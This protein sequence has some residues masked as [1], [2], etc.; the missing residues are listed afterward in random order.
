MTRLVVKGIGVAGAFGTGVE[1]F[2]SALAEGRATVGSVEVATGEGVVTVPAYR[3]DTAALEEFVPKRALR[4]VDNYSK[5]ALLGSYLALKDAG[6]LGADLGRLGLV[7]ASGYGA[8][9]TTYAFLDSLISG[10]DT[11]ASPTHFANSVHNA[12]AANV[13]ITL[14]IRG[15]S[16]TVSQFDMSVPSAL[17][18]ARQWLAEG[19]VDAVLFGAVDEV[20]ELVAYLQHRRYGPRHVAAMAPFDAG[21][22]SSIIGEGAAFLVLTRDDGGTAYC[23]IDSVETGNV[24][25]GGLSLPDDALMLLGADGRKELGRR[26]LDTVAAGATAACYTP[27]Y[28]SMPAAAAFDLA[29]AALALKN[30]QA[31]ASPAGPGPFAPDSAG[32]SRICSLR[33]AGPS[34]YATVLMSKL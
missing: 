1:S 5:L 12:A 34:E 6:M 19:R 15:P 22:E 30:G 14:G 2:Q 20:S 27:I 16:L 11:C 32:V 21:T 28:G 9:A 8:T 29:A 7:I 17:V 33:L 26:Y 13:A 31:F 10:G 24:F 4:R 23:G 18:S 25:G 3:A